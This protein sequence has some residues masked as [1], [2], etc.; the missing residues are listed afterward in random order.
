MSLA[1]EN[2]QPDERDIIKPLDHHQPIAGPKG[3]R[4]VGK[5]EQ[6]VTPGDDIIKPLDHHQPIG[7]PRGDILGDPK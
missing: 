1:T 3:R 4:I 6:P 5:N 2:T 7:T